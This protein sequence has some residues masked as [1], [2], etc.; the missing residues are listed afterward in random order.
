[1]IIKMI[2]KFKFV[3]II[4][5]AI[6]ITTFFKPG[7]AIKNWI[8]TSFFF[9]EIMSIM[10]PMLIIVSLLD[11]WIP[12]GMIKSQFGEKSGIKGWITAL[13]LGSLAAGPLIAA[14]PIAESL[15]RRGARTSNIVIFLGSWA[16]IKIPMIL[17]ESKFLGLRFSLVRVVLT[18]PLIILTGLIMQNFANLVHLSQPVSE[19]KN[20]L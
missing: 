11:A 15:A 16:T 18:V 9:T 8:N 6:L 19:T 12:S 20:Q 1:M 5:I 4:Q 2:N 3:L 13:L 14:F 7:F 10:P 17:F